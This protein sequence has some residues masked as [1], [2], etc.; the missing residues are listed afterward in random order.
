M[1]VN[2]DLS[3]YMG[4]GH[5]RTSFHNDV[6][7]II[8]DCAQTVGLPMQKTPVE[9][10][11]GAIPLAARE[12]YKATM[13]AYRHSR[14]AGQ[15]R[16]GVVPDLLEPLTQQ[17]HDIKTTGLKREHYFA[18]LP[19]VDLKAATVPASYRARAAVADLQYNGVPAGQLGPVGALGEVNRTTASLLSRLADVGSDNPERFGCCHGK[20][21]AQGVI[22]SYIGRRFGRIVLRGIVR[23][24]HTALEKAVGPAYGASSF[25]VEGLLARA[26]RVP[27]TRGTSLTLALPF[28]PRPKSL[29]KGGA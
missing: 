26:M 10:F 21:Q 4:E 8:Y 27:E 9:V 22:A 1:L 29:L 18:G 15:A 3:L 5:A 20:R 17:M 28:R 6:Q 24:R 13:R 23:V 11:I 2:N 14:N 16:G 25:R 7:N 12:R 19:S